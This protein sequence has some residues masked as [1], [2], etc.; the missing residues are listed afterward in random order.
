MSSSSRPQSG[1]PA[2]L[3]TLLETLDRL[4]EL[5]EDMTDL[6]VASRDEAETLMREINARVDEMEAADPER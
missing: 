5:I 4:E 2:D 3:V 1:K 6:G